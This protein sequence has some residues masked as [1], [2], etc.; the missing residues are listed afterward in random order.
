MRVGV[1]TLQRSSWPRGRVLGGC[2]SIN[3]NIHM[4]GSP[5]DFD[6][7]EQ[8]YGATGWGF[9]EMLKFSNKAECRRL[10][11]KIF[12]QQ[13]E[14]C[15]N[16]PTNDN[17]NNKKQGCNKNNNNKNT[18]NNKEGGEGGRG[19]VG[20]GVQHQ[21]TRQHQDTVQCYDPPVRTLTSKSTLTQAFLDAGKELGIPVGNLNDDIDH[22][23]MAASTTVYKGTRWSNVR[24][25]LRPA[26]TRPNL[27]VLLHTHVNKVL[28]A[29]GRA[30]GVQFIQW[31]NPGYNGTVYARGEVVLSA[32]TIHTPV[33]LTHSGIGPGSLLHKLKIPL[34]SDVLGVGANLQ[35]HLNLPVYVSL[36]KPVSLNPDKMRSITNLW[37]YFVN[38]GKGDMGRAAIEG[39]GAIKGSSVGGGGKEG[40]SSP[41]LGI[42]LFNMAAVDKHM[43]S[44]VSNMKMEYFDEL[45]PG[46]DNQSAEGFIFL[47]SCLHPK[48]RGDVVVVSPDPRYAPAINPNYLAHPYD[49]TCMRDA[50]KMAVR[51]ARTKAFRD[52]GA[53]VHLP[54]FP[55]CV[56]GVGEGG[57]GTVDDTKIRYKDYVDCVVR[58][59][60]ITGYHPIGTARLGNPNT[61]PYAVVDPTLSVVG[62]NRLRV[63]DA[64]VMPTLTSGTPN[65]VI[66]VIAEKAAH[67]IKERWGNGSTLADERLCDSSPEC[68]EELLAAVNTAT[69][70]V[71]HLTTTTTLILTLTLIHFRA[72]LVL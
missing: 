71:T 62:V 58:V 25:Y 63:V 56:G 60:G 35:D 14:E 18:K 30:V 50:F 24:G 6:V 66:T 59:A 5:M 41:D 2:S 36:T 11:P 65:S 15:S 22:G 72:Y 40:Q 4:L 13:Q 69:P 68:E 3:Y 10:R 37:Q 38:G 47:A 51:L 54:R 8:Q 34:V 26:L 52:L 43:Y 48:S 53:S 64:S 57:D 7:W 67:M 12:K 9:D 17:N 23:V 20:G 21:H 55:E 61:D 42:I 45:F 28:F 46:M 1:F 39:V 70:T 16:E 29:G 44:S 27:H 31:D 32:G 33:I 49:R 19:G